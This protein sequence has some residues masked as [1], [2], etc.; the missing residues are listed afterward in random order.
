MTPFEELWRWH[1]ELL[2]G[3]FTDPW[4]LRPRIAGPAQGSLEQLRPAHTDIH[5]TESSFIADVELPGV[6]KEDIEVSIGNDVLEVKVQKTKEEKRKDAFEKSFMGFYKSIAL[7][8]NVDV[9]GIEAE[10]RNGM[11][12][13][14]MPK[15]EVDAAGNTRRI[16]VK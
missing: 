16:Q 2:D 7:P 14:T 15:V 12:R 10:Y 6:R 5:E 4:T 1:N 13:I 3:F 11:L 9:Q 8:S